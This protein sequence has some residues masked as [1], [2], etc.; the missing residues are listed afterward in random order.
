L[1]TKQKKESKS[2]KI[3]NDIKKNAK[4]GDSLTELKLGK[5]TL[6]DFR[7][8]LPNGEVIIPWKGKK[9][10]IS[11]WARNSSAFYSK[12]VRIELG[13]FL[14]VE[15]DSPT[16]TFDGNDIINTTMDIATFTSD[17]SGEKYNI[18]SRL[19]PSNIRPNNRVWIT[20]LGCCSIVNVE[21][22]E[23][24]IV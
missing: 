18:A 17:K 14:G 12:E 15:K 6:M 20:L 13:H 8:Y 19:I 16:V 10:E 22:A 11:E 3:L 1:P 9:T 7:I 4:V 24:N 21:K 23:D 2:K 5:A